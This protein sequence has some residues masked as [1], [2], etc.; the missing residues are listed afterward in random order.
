M[1]AEPAPETDL[2]WLRAKTQSDAILRYHGMP[3]LL[4]SL[5]DMIQWWLAKDGAA[6]SKQDKHRA[7]MTMLCKIEDLTGITCGPDVQLMRALHKLCEGGGSGIWTD[8]DVTVSE[9]FRA[10]KHHPLLPHHDACTDSFHE[11]QVFVA[12]AFGSHVV[13]SAAHSVA[14]GMQLLKEQDVDA[15]AKH[16]LYCRQ[17][18]AVSKQVA[19]VSLPFGFQPTLVA[20][21]LQQAF[22]AHTAALVCAAYALGI[23]GKDKLALDYARWVD[24]CK[25]REWRQPFSM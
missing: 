20:A 8:A 13:L 7:A 15:S 6:A 14:I 4:G 17:D 3:G 1:S 24:G 9:R 12:L 23:L 16:A 19:C 22:A 21:R 10:L 11:D 2:A 18:A 5:P 25:E